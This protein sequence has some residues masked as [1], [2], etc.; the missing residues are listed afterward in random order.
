MTEDFYEADRN[1]S[2]S[3]NI[4]GNMKS[5]SESLIDEIKKNNQRRKRKRERKR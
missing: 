3:K 5:D 4:H 1:N 2:N